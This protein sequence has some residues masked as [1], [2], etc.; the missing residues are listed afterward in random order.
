MKKPLVN[1]DLL[2]LSIVTFLGQFTISM[3]NLAFVYYFRLVFD[4]SAQMIGLSAA[5]YTCSYFIF[6]FAVGP[7]A[8]KMVPSRS[9]QISMAGMAFSLLLLLATRNVYIAFFSLIVYGASM[10]FL[11]PQL[12]AWI[13]RGKEGELLSRSTA[14]FNVSW[15]VGAALSP[16]LTGYLVGKSPSLSIIVSMFIFIGVIFILL[17]A[18]SSIPSIKKVESENE[19]IRRSG[20]KDESTPLRFFCWGGNLTMYVALAVILTIFPIY[21]MDALP[22]SSFQVGILLFLRGLSTV[23]FFHHLGKHHWWHFNSRAIGGTLA[24]FSITALIATRFESFIGYMLFFIVFGALFSAMYTFSI[25][26]GASGSR[27]RSKRM[28]I[29]EAVLT[30]GTVIGSTLGATLYQYFGFTRV[31][32]MCSVIVLIPLAAL[33]AFNLKRKTGESVPN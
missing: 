29:H 31:L 27:Y 17:Y 16:L 24:I 11:W 25:F 6:C 8:S 15:S 23:F 2:I 5:L 7:V 26:H 21:A 20:K 30:V 12:A 22:F 32:Y 33:I 28:L 1:P 10:A 9:I 3:A 19:N 4:L 14:L 18:C 13:T